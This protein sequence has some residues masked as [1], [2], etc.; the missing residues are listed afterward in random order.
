MILTYKIKHNRD[1][2]TELEKAR[3]IA[4]FALKTKS[5]SSK[6]VKHIELKSAIANQIL[7]KYSLNKKLKRISS[8]KLTV[9]G[10]SIKFKNNRIKIPCL[11]M[12]MDFEKDIEK[13]NQIEFDQEFAYISCT[14]KEAEKI[15][16]EGWLGIDRNT[17][18]HCAVVAD[19][20]NNKVIL[21]GKAAQ[22]IHKKYSKIRKKFQKKKKLKKLKAIKRRES[23]IQ[24]DINHK[25]SKK[26]VNYAKNNKCGIKLE[27][28]KDI[29]QTTKQ[30]KSF[31]YSMNSWAYFQLE[32]FIEYKAQLAGVSVV[33]VDPAYTSQAC[34]KCH[35]LGNRN[36]KVFKCPH[37]GYTSHADVNASW[38]ISYSEKLWVEPK[39][40][41]R[42]KSGSC[43]TQVYNPRLIRE[44]VRIK[45]NTD[46]PQG[47]MAMQMQPTLEPLWL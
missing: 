18:G 3:E 32:Q 19:N 22:H 10:L 15:E 27:K 47:A 2:S 34:H 41:H 39:P 26:I 35:Q 20:K 29:R 5:R 1:F 8:V 24:K 17:T 33:Y 21:L 28:L 13:I 37:C 4:I 16:C 23:N 38:N 7:K 25:T 45:G 11:K 6:D 40:E 44:G 31:K 36:G 30:P 42:P 9:P 14:V 46:I 43:D 12:E